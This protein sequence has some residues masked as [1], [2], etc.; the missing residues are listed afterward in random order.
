MVKRYH[1]SRAKLTD[2]LSKS[3]CN[4][5]VMHRVTHPYEAKPWNVYRTYFLTTQRIQNGLNY[6]K[7]H[8]DVLEYAE[9]HYGI[10]PPI[11][12]AIIG[13]ESNYGALVGEFS[14]LDALTT[15]AFHYKKR[16]KFFARELVQ[17]LLLAKEQKL[18][19]KLIKSSYA[20][21][22]GIPQFMPGTYRCYQINYL[23]NAHVDLIH[24]DDEA[25]ISIANFL[26]KNGWKIHQ[27]IAYKLTVI[28]SSDPH[29]ISKEAIAQKSINFLKKN[30]ITISY[31]LSSN[32][33]VTVVRLRSENTDEY[34]LT[35]HNFYVIMRYNPRVIYAMAVYQL[36]QAIQQ[37]H[38]Q[39]LLNKDRGEHSKVIKIYEGTEIG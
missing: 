17:L 2:I 11:I 3:K 36:S 14:A 32:Q 15:L 34:W 5:D 29:L 4:K 38:G 8:K 20:G 28:K 25:I 37:E 19:L 16:E 31:S 23:K 24:N 13:I 18:T 7:M 33:K 39:Q 27:P 26:N 21:A 30:G 22:I 35:L 12:V 6:W 9:H 1:F 10:P